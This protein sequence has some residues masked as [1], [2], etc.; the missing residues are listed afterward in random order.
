MT[1][2]LNQEPSQLE[3][4]LIVTIAH[5][6]IGKEYPNVGQIVEAILPIIHKACNQ[7]RIETANF[8]WQS[9]NEQYPDDKAKLDAWLRSFV[10]AENINANCIKELKEGN[11]DE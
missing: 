3:K 1:H 6:M 8:I 11:L 4:E 2:L 10:I 9:Y 5:L 7:A